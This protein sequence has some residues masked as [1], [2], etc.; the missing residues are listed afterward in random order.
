MAL[1]AGRM[2]AP[3]HPVPCPATSSVAHTFLQD[4]FALGCDSPN[5][6]PVPLHEL[7]GVIQEFGPVE[8]QS[9]R[10]QGGRPHRTAEASGQ[11]SS[12]LQSRRGKASGQPGRGPNRNWAVF[13]KGL[14]EP[15][16]RQRPLCTRP[17]LSLLRTRARPL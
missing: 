10:P 15:F 6:S 9:T 1:R 8:R 13:T 5:H 7:Q 11:G 2:H 17:S 14:C 12:E 3:S 16:L 4:D